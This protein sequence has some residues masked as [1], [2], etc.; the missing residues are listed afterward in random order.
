MIHNSFNEWVV[1]EVLPLQRKNPTWLRLDGLHS[2]GNRNIVGKFRYKNRVW[3]VHGDTRFDPVIRAHQ[4]I[5]KGTV[6]PF[7]IGR[8]RVR[9]CLDLLPTLKVPKRPKYFY[10]YG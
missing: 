8:A 6:A 4:A 10:V 5:K 3:V 2:G 1:L 9:D 7:V